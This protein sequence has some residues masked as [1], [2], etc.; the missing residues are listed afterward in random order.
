MNQYLIILDD[1]DKNG[2]SKRLAS[3]WLEVHG[4]T[5]E[6]LEVLAKEA[7]PGKQYLRDE[8]GSIQAKLADGKY[9]WCYTK[10][11]L[12]T[13]YVPTAAEVRK[14]KIQEIKAET[15]A[16]NEPLQ[17][18]MLTALLQGNDKL[19]AQLRDQYQANNKA[20]IDAIKE[21]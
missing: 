8:N 18:R 20:M 16:A 17:E 4:D 7:Y 19:A 14:A 2:E 9:V 12:P 6:E 3:Y 11:V 21:V 13:P 1:P 10:P 15:D 5:W